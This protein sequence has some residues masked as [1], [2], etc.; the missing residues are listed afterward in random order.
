MITSSIQIINLVTRNP[1]LART[2]RIHLLT[3]QR[4]LY[5]RFYRTQSLKW[6]RISRKVT[7]H[8]LITYLLFSVLGGPQQEQLQQ[9]LSKMKNNQPETQTEPIQDKSPLIDEVDRN[10]WQQVRV[11]FLKFLLKIYF[12][13]RRHFHLLMENRYLSVR[14]LRQTIGISTLLRPTHYCLHQEPG[15]ILHRPDCPLPDM[16]VIIGFLFC[17]M[18]KIIIIF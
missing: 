17:L 12:S 18:F 6:P 7:I 5:R 8:S 9:I 4:F 11:Y 13:H 1:L 15:S 10:S 14:F 2:N 3:T 16:I